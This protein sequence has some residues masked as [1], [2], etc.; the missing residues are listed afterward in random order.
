MSTSSMLKPYFSMS[1]SVCIIMKMP[2]RLPTKFGESL[3]MIGFL[4]RPTKKSRNW[5]T[6]SGATCRVGMSSTSARKRT[7]LKKWVPMK[8][9]FRSSEQSLTISLTERPEVLVAT[10]EPLR[11]C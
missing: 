7:G 4:P 6:S 1:W 8:W 10:M 3:A 2:T 11:R 9:R 5:C